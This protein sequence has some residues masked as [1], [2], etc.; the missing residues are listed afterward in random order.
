MHSAM[1]DYTDKIP[2]KDSIDKE[3][4]MS[5]KLSNQFCSD[6]KDILLEMDVHK[7][8]LEVKRIGNIYYYRGMTVIFNNGQRISKEF[9][10]IKKYKTS[11]LKNIIDNKVLLLG[12]T[13]MPDK[14]LL[15][16]LK[17]DHSEDGIVKLI[18][19]TILTFILTII[20]AKLGYILLG[21]VVL[22][23]ADMIISLFPG[24]IKPG[25]EQEHT[26]KKKFNSFAVNIIAISGVVKGVEY[27]SKGIEIVNTISSIAL[28]T[29]LFSVYIIRIARYVARVNGTRLPKY[30]LD[31][32]KPKEES[33][34]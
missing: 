24:C 27:L 28:V 25:T 1:F 15:A 3:K 26:I 9:S 12:A 20:G 29:W 4:A 16:D 22:A 7:V 34:E 18:I 31:R 17:K 14:F 6:N 2:Y 5:D 23:L 21:L 33:K 11:T 32:F 10:L 19:T 13:L 30:V 8:K